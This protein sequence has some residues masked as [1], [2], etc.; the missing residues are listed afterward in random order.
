MKYARNMKWKATKNVKLF[1]EIM[2]NKKRGE[3]SY[4]K[5]QV[6]CREADATGGRKAIKDTAEKQ[7]AAVCNA[8]DSHCT[9]DYL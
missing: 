2:H 1:H 7:L 6:I 5:P 4:E 9:H 8:S 3:Q